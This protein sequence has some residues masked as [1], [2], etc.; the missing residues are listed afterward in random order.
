MVWYYFEL[1]F[2]YKK[3]KRLS[4]ICQRFSSFPLLN[5]LNCVSC[6]HVLSFQASSYSDKRDAWTFA[7]YSCCCWFELGCHIFKSTSRFTWP[8]CGELF[9]TWHCFQK[10]IKFKISHDLAWSPCVHSLLS[11]LLFH[12]LQNYVFQGD[13]PYFNKLIR[14]M[15]TRCMTQVILLKLLIFRSTLYMEFLIFIYLFFA[16]T[17][18]RQYISVVENSALQ[19]F[20]IMGLQHLFILIS[21]HLSGDILVSKRF[22][23]VQFYFLLMNTIPEFEF[24][25]YFLADVIVHRLLAASIGIYKLPTI[26]RDRPQLTSI[27]DSK[28]Q[29]TFQLK[30]CHGLTASSDLISLPFHNM[31]ILSNIRS[32]N[33]YVSSIEP[34]H[35][36]SI[37]DLIN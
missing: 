22:Y 3:S 8:C 15:A 25:F 24:W 14:I 35:I 28:Q 10:N 20:F 29:W 18:I 9:F 11:F 1:L 36:F 30:I 5:H 12:F 27:A 37:I 19:N 7:S 13:D 33:W 2:C 23:L 31:F 6:G 34:N 21:H 26:F 17:L 32:S 16:W 4:F